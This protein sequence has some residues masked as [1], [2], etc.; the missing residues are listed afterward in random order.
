MNEHRGVVFV[1][2]VVAVFAALVGYQ[3]ASQDPTNT[4]TPW[5]NFLA[6]TLVG[7]VVCVVA[8][9][10]SIDWVEVDDYLFGIA[11]FSVVWAATGFVGLGAYFWYINPSEATR[12]LAWL[13]YCFG[14]VWHFV[15]ATVTYLAVLREDQQKAAAKARSGPAASRHQAA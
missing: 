11:G 10:R 9:W 15:C 2:F 6:V 13:C 8:L 3:V 12:N 14:L 5:A 7:V 1:T 4:G